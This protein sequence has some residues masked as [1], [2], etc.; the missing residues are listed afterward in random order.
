MGKTSGK[1]GGAHLGQVALRQERFPVKLREPRTP[2]AALFEGG[3]AK[4][5]YDANATI[6][7]ALPLDGKPPFNLRF[8]DI[9]RPPD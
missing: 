3:E 5:P 6:G 1:R 4:S 2:T 9:L 7:E 8:L